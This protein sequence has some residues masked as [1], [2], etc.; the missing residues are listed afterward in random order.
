MDNLGRLSSVDWITHVSSTILTAGLILF[1]VA[2]G[3][4]WGGVIAINHALNAD[5]AVSVASALSEEFNQRITYTV[6]VSAF[7]I[8][9][10]V[11]MTQHYD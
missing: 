4:K 3:L 1:G 10:G 5:F 6:V 2:L 11:F 8:T 9:T 7:C